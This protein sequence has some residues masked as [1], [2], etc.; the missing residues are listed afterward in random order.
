MKPTVPL[1]DRILRRVD[2][3]GPC[4][5]W[6][7][8]LNGDEYGVVGRGRQGEGN[9][10]VHRAVWT[11]LVGEIPHGLDLD[12]LCRNPRCCNPDHLEPVTRKE[13]VARG[14]RRP[15]YRRDV[16]TC[17]RGHAWTAENTKQLLTQRK[18]RACIRED[19]RA[20]YARDKG[21]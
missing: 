7:G 5:E 14:A 19:S 12:H 1:L 18:C 4:W 2:A 17:A 13:N 15:G 9:V 3:E 11:L 20:K 8:A 10:L 21:R 16:P 6:T